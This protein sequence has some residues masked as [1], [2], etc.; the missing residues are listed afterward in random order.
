MRFSTE[1]LSQTFSQRLRRNTHDNEYPKPDQSQ[2]VYS[3]AV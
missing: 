2:K 1:I 3:Y